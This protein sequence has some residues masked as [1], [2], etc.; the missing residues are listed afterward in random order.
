MGGV[1]NGGPYAKVGITTGLI[2]PYLEGLFVGLHIF[3]TRADK[4]LRVQ[5]IYY[6]LGYFITRA[7][8]DM[9][10]CYVKSLQ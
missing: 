9:T 7:G 5:M 2:L 6:A 1:H 8:T 4:L 3:I 10:K